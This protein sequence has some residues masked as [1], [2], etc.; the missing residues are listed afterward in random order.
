MTEASPCPTCGEDL[1]PG[2]GGCLACLATQTGAPVPDGRGAYTGPRQIAG[3]RIEGELGAGG[4][5]TVF[6]AWDEKMERRVALKVMS[7]HLAP[8]EKA[9][10]RFEQEAWI[11]GKLNHPN[12]VKVFDR[13]RFEE[14]SFYS[15]EIV[16]G[17]SLADVISNMKRWGRDDRWKL[18]RG[19]SEYVRWAIS[20]VIDTARA[21]DFAHE[22]G[23]VHRDIKP[24]NLLL[25]ADSCTVKVADFGLAIDSEATRLT[26]AGKTLGTLAYMAPEQ[27]LGKQDEMDARTDVYALGVTLF[28]L[29]TLELPYTGKTQQLYMN[30]VLTN[31]A[32]RPSKLNER[33]G[34]DLEI[35]IRK[36]LEKSHQDR[37][38]SAADLA[39]DLE[40]ILHL[41]P[42]VAR[43]TPWPR[44]VAMWARRRPMRA[45]L[46]AVLIIGVPAVA[47]L[48]DRALE[49][50]GLVRAQ[51][52][53]RLD[54]EL[55]FLG[56]LARHEDLV[57]KASEILRVDPGNL[58][59]LRARAVGHLQLSLGEPDRA[60]EFVGRSLTDIET[61]IR[62]HPGTSWPYR[63]KAWALDSIGR[64]PE[65]SEAEQVSMQYRSDPPSTE[66]LE[67]EGLHA[68]RTGRWEEADVI[69]T[70]LIARKADDPLVVGYR[71][72]AR[73]ALG[74]IDDAIVDYRVASGL[75]PNDFLIHYRL[76]RLQ[77]ESGE[78][79]EAAQHY[80]RALE[81]DPENAFV[82]EALAANALERGRQAVFSNDL[83]NSLDLFEQAERHAR[84]SLA[85]RDDLINAHLN[86]GASLMEQNRVVDDFDPAKIDEALEHY[87]RARQSSPASPD[88]AVS[89]VVASANLCDALIQLDR[90]E[91]SLEVCLA[92][93]EQLPDDAV[94]F[95]NLAGAYALAGRAEESLAALER[96]F[97][98][99]DRDYAYLLSDAW[100]ETL[101][102][103]PRFRDLI[104]RM[105][106]D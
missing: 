93:A 15:M 65:S 97:E 35:V 20:R 11:A 24:V 41:R 101:R 14:L 12:I 42:I 29:L 16:D 82:H 104:A 4:M 25:L 36:A 88:E 87:D 59:A 72:D 17:G 44:K 9:G 73:E 96:D 66:D 64:G 40:N 100:F 105:R 48:A 103:D 71:G 6:E 1:P 61:I 54:E 49:H 57:S 86:L 22:R 68:Q 45:A 28:E 63:L 83:E 94:A 23:V 69:Y 53:E 89:V 10:F 43:P 90:I 67:F 46:V 26:T 74:R 80:A 5:G 13:G 3:Y 38:V 106:S 33:V 58:A 37:Y 51:V 76:G 98:L 2:D 85:L 18:E 39:D 56:R 31:E 95:Y 7:R 81:I 27:I 102:D 78:P 70:E 34:R 79:D 60:V 55:H 8:S 21:L 32:R 62:L 30:S 47:F 19:S 84:R 75:R 52:I 92:A 99:G 91:Q 50:R 77:A